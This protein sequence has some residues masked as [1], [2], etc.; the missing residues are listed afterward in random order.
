MLASMGA[1]LHSPER[2][3]CGLPTVGQK[4][5]FVAP[6]HMARGKSDSQAHSN[7]LSLLRLNI[8]CEKEVAMA[9][10]TKRPDEGIVTPYINLQT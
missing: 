8:R 4:R 7:C 9:T 3:P 1:G 2:H 5:R 10:K 6:F